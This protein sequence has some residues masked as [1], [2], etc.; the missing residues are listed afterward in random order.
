MPGFYLRTIADSLRWGLILG[1]WA[2]IGYIL[3][4]VAW[5]WAAIWS[6]PGLY[7]LMNLIGFATLPIYH[8]IARADPRIKEAREMLEDHGV[9]ERNSN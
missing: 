9:Y 1:S 5:Y 7:V 6:L 3:W 2:F 8:F 4:S